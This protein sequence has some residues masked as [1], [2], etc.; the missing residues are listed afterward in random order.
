MLL[1]MEVEAMSRKQPVARRRRRQPRK[2]IRP[3]LVYT[4]ALVALLLL[5]TLFY[6]SRTPAV[7]CPK[8][9]MLY[10]RAIGLADPA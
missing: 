4:L 3:Q 9:G 10:P 7:G 6:A 8:S 1:G 5:V 2:G